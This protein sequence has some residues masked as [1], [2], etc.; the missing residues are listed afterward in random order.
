MVLGW[1]SEVCRCAYSQTGDPV[2]VTPDLLARKTKLGEYGF[3]LQAFDEWL[4][5]ACF[6]KAFSPLDMLHWEQRSGSWEAEHNDEV[7]MAYDV[8]SFFNCRELLTTLLSVDETYRR[9]PEHKLY[10]RLVTHMWPE[11][12]SEPINPPVPPVSLAERSVDAA[13]SVVRRLLPD[14][15]AAPLKRL[16]MYW[17]NR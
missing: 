6:A 13:K 17:R 4:S 14:S 15:A 5:E 1:I 8:L 12:L 11:G 3:T 10:Q 2:E 16:M 7:A 9:G